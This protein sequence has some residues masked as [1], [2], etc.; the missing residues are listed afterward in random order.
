MKLISRTEQGTYIVELVKEDLKHY[1]VLRNH[2][3]ILLGIAHKADVLSKC[4]EQLIN[5][6]QNL[7]TFLKNHHQVISSIAEAGTL[8]SILLQNKRN[9]FNA[10]IK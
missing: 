8:T 2:Q 5:A 4:Y 7:E 10:Q 1:D 3:G 6:K 9:D